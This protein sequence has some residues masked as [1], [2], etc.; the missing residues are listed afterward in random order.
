MK[1][2]ATLEEEIKI[3]KLNLKLLYDENIN[4]KQLL[5]DQKQITLANKK[6]ISIL[7]K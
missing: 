3:L 1:K 4:L 2:I 7:I 5:D 6:L